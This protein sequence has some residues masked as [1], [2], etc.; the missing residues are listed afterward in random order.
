MN[1]GLQDAFRHNAWATRQV[2]QVCQG[3][4]ESQ[5]QL[6]APG[7]YGSIIATLWHIVRSEASYCRRL[8]GEEPA[9]D[10]RAS[11]A[12]SLETL[13]KHVDDLAARWE[14]FL[15]EPFDAERIFVIKWDDD[16]D[17]DVPAGVVL[18]QALHHGNEHRTQVCTVLTSIG[19]TAPELGV[20]EFAEA[21]KRAAPRQS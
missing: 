4:T 10:F 20:W 14:R 9:W 2:L 1:D 16:T 11:D 5:L 13:A 7:T 6:T 12:P 15:A 19:V 8:T 17:F 3:L 21:T 18:V